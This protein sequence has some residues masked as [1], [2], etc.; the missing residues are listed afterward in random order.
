ME[1]DT[2][3]ALAKDRPAALSDY[4]TPA[5]ADDLSIAKVSTKFSTLAVDSTTGLANARQL[6][7]TSQFAQ[8]DKKSTPRLLFWQGVQSGFPRALPTNLAGTKSLYWN[9]ST[10]LVNW[11]WG[12]M[13]AFRRQIHYLD[14]KLLL[15]EADHAGYDP[16][17]PCEWCQLPTRALI[18]Q[19]PT[20]SA[21]LCT[22]GE[23]VM[24]P[25]NPQWGNVRWRL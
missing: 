13:E 11:A 18:Q 20:H 21:Y 15:S 4:L 24:Q 25:P 19:L 12:K 5:F 14:C 1:L 22:A 7:A 3:D 23:R 10:G 2:N 6:G 16:K 8:L 9:G 17:S